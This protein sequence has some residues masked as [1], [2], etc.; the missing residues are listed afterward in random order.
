VNEQ[1]L[2]AEILNAVPRALGLT[3]RQD[4]SE[5]FGCCDRAYWHYRQIDFAN[6]R[7]QEIGLMLAYAHALPINK[8]PYYQKEALVRW[9]VGIWAHWLESR[10]V[11]GAVCEAYPN[12]RSVCATAFTAAAF[13][14][15]AHLLKDQYDWQ[16]ML[17]DAER[18]MHW[19]S[20]HTTTDAFNQMAASYLALSGYA[21]LTGRDDAAAWASSRRDV[22]LSLI[23]D[24][25]VLPEYGG[26]DSGYQSLSLATLAAAERHFGSNNSI[27]DALGKASRTMRDNFTPP[28]G[29]DTAANAR[30][31]QY[32]FPSGL[33]GVDGLLETQIMP[34]IEAGRALRP[35]WM[36]DRYFIGL[37]TDFMRLRHTQQI[38]AAG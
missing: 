26:F 13:I 3:D 35:S 32:V 12:E 21:A 27:R 31:T 6:A 9:S 5:T 24:D 38:M 4:R 18:T 11:D 22:L 28:F 34:S 30:R 19:L 10:T 16:P 25:G 29:F 14:E 1:F 36:D 15:T 37:A 17:A 2:D 8:N 20:E 33:S 23:R 7:F